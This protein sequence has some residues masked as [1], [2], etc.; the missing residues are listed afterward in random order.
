M[1]ARSGLFLI[2]VTAC[3]GGSS[4]TRDDAAVQRDGMG[5]GSS[6]TETRVTG[7]IAGTNFELRYAAASWGPAG[8]PRIWVCA[9]NIPVTYADCM[10]S[11]GSPRVMMLGPYIYDSNGVPR[12]DVAELAQYRVGTNAVTELARSGTITIHEDSAESKTLTASFSVD[13]GGAVPTAGS[14]VVTP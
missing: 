4:S 13:F 10:Q 5:S 14:V 8:D 9:A 3:S 2:F 12:W 1:R 7:V 11:G 6:P